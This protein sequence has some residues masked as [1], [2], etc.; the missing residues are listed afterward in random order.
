MRPCC[1]KAAVLRYCF[2][3]ATALFCCCVRAG[4]V[5]GGAVTGG[6]VVGG[7]VAG[8]LIGRDA[9]TSAA[10]LPDLDT[11]RDFPEQVTETL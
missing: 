2:A 4:V 10:V 1:E 5:T 6:A 7:D 9:Q 8:A 3:V 11:E